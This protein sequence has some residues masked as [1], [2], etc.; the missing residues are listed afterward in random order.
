MKIIDIHIY[1]GRWHWPL[2]LDTVRDTLDVMDRCG[3]DTGI[4][5][6]VEAIAY[7]FRAG[8]AALAREIE[9]RDRLF[10]YVV[11]NGHYPE[12]S[13]EQIERYLGGDHRRGFVGVKVH[14]SY[15]RIA[16]DDADFRPIF[17]RA[18]DFGKPVLVHTSSTAL[19]APLTVAQVAAEYRDIP[20][21]LGHMGRN[22]WEPAI[23]AAEQRN[24]HLDPCC[25][26]PD[27]PKI[28]QTV[29][30]VGAEKILF[31][32]A[33]MENHPAYT[34]GMIEG[35]GLSDAQRRLIYHAN[36]ER[37]FRLPVSAPVSV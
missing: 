26:F 30:R 13:V 29:A 24:V 28:E 9:E 10:G 37:L 32:S 18:A 4:A 1:Q 7:D 11:V 31:G 2:G 27:A 16:V 14:P 19:T 34:I 3:I 36:A 8:N 21:I 5:M 35:A 12:Q 33:M 6:S 17:R 22:I 25:S 15:S 20:F 23:R